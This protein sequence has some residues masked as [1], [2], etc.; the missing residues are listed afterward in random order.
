MGGSPKRIVKKVV[1]PI[2]KIIPKEVKPVLPAIAAIYGPA[3]LAKTAFGTASGF[4][5]LAPGIQSA[6][7]NAATQ[8]ITT[9][10]IDPKEAAISGI[11]AQLGA[12]AKLP[13]G[14]VDTGGLPTETILSTSS[15]TLQPM[16][17]ATQ[18]AKAAEI[19]KQQTPFLQR[20]LSNLAPVD[21][22]ETIANEGIMSAVKQGAIAATPASSYAVGR[23]LKELNEQMIRDYEAS[24]NKG[25]G[26]DGQEGTP[27]DKD[28]RRSM[29]FG[30]FTNAGYEPG[31]VN[32]IL[33]KYGYADG[34]RVGFEEGG[35]VTISREE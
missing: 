9:G 6:I 22:K 23:E 13:K 32:T 14:P 35:Q 5:S 7:V 8:G 15:K 16:A 34:G 18:A 1:K 31:Y 2:K 11:T 29:I 26:P 20:T 19:A 28:T 3:A 21:L 10:K 4:A 27:I 30:Y 24:L 12:K 33:D 25:V 17:T